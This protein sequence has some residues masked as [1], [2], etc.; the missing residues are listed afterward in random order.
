MLSHHSIIYVAHSIQSYRG[1]KGGSGT[2]A[3]QQHSICC[4]KSKGHLPYRLKLGVS[5]GALFSL[6]NILLFYNLNPIINLKEIAETVHYFQD[7]HVQTSSLP[8]LPVVCTLFDKLCTHAQ[9]R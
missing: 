3:W 9:G 5:E 8:T 1:R 4:L 2:F 7:A 6:P